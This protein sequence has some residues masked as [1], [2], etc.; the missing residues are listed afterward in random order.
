MISILICVLVLMFYTFFASGEL[1]SW[2][3]KNNMEYQHVLTNRITPQN[4]SQ[5]T[6]N[7]IDDL[8]D[9][10]KAEMRPENNIK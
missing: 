7:N 5:E 10:L 9:R 3:S 6:S 8:T 2:A 4:V 1:Q